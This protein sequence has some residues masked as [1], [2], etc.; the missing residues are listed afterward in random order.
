MNDI[1]TKRERKFLV[2]HISDKCKFIYFTTLKTASFTTRKLMDTNKCGYGQ[3]I[4]GNKNFQKTCGDHYCN[5]NDINNKLL[6]NNYFKF[7]FTRNP[8]TRFE[9]V[10]NFLYDYVPWKMLMKMNIN[11]YNISIENDD[12]IS[13]KNENEKKYLLF[14]KYFYFVIKNNLAIIG[15]NKH[16]SFTYLQHFQPIYLSLCIN[17]NNNKLCFK[18]DFVAKIEYLYDNLIYLN[19]SYKLNMYLNNNIF[20]STHETTKN[21]IPK[22]LTFKFIKNA[23]LPLCSLYWN[24]FICSNYNIPLECQ[25]KNNKTWHYPYFCV[26]ILNKKNIWPHPL[27]SRQS[28]DNY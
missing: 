28:T 2:I 7:V 8:I 10:Y 27:F 13:F 17:D 1:W 12:I 9:S 24:D 4:Y 16:K 23:L 6:N 25:L 21:I 19:N 22:G 26:D 15:H 14:I 18:P 20:N 3:S 11:R 5:L